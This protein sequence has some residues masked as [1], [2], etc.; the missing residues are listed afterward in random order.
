MPM[1]EMIQFFRQL[2]GKINSNL[3]AGLPWSS[4]PQHHAFLRG[5][6]KELKQ[7]NTLQ[8]PL[9]EL[10][11]VVF[12]IET[13][14]FYPEK[15]DQMIS[16]GAVKM[17]GAEMKA[18][19]TFYTLVKSDL[20]LSKEISE[21]TSIQEMELRHAPNPADVLVDFFKFIKSNI[22]V[23]H[24]SNHELNFMRKMTRD[25]L[26]CSF[27]HRIVDTSFLL[28]LEDPSVNPRPLEE[29]CQNC[30][31][32]IKNRHHALGDA[33]MTAK[34]WSHYLNAAETKGFKNLQEIYEYL[35][36]LK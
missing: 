11:V 26:R 7:T 29:I 35:S 8:I 36:K 30:G 23:A 2:S 17:I 33:L 32:E 27:D 34:I 4:S 14:G 10:P 13:T 28:R 25:Y 6:Q 31:I 1:N 15:G 18:E 21:L 20:P 9:H 22:L 12:D 16:I 5:L 24:H 3:Y 19:E